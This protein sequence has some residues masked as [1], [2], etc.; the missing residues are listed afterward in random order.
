MPHKEIRK[1]LKT[2]D[3]FTSRKRNMEIGGP[4]LKKRRNLISLHPI[5]PVITESG[6]KATSPLDSYKSEISASNI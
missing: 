5:I 1:R 3:I 6:A 2:L 4:L